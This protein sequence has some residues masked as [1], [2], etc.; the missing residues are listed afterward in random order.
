[1]INTNNSNIKNDD[2]C[3]VIGGVHKG[4]SGTVKDLNRSKTGHLTLTVLQPNGMRFKT[5]AKNVQLI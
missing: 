1:M 3:T 5:L 4:K 2:S